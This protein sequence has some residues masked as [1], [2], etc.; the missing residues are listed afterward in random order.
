M[1]RTAEERKSEI[2]D[3]ASELFAQKG[4]DGTSTNDI[5][6]KVG[7]ARGALYHHFKSK[8]DIL[9]S[10][11][12]W[13]SLQMLQAAEKIAA[14]KSIPVKERIICT[15]MALNIQHIGGDEIIRQMHRPQNALMHEKAQCAMIK[16]VP[17]ILTK[18][19]Q[20][21]IEQGLFDTPYPY[22]CVELIVV[23]IDTVLSSS[24]IELSD[25]ERMLR[26]RAFLFHIE[27]MLGAAPDSLMEIAEVF[28]RKHSNNNQ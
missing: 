16:G 6:E 7:I 25:E 19:I 3:A 10:L 21:G 14:N 13:Y 12:N 24:T 9:D 5:L 18:I 4:Y 17:P 26:T 15:I 20:E 23:Y 11:I 8:E 27:R 2:L 1:R 22:E 28:G